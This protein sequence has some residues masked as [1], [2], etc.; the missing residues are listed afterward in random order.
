M[1][2][3]EI[4]ICMTGGQL[5]SPNLPPFFP[6]SLPSSFALCNHISQE[7]GPGGDLSHVPC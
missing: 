3:P 6:S 5:G 7:Q 4:W 2:A 1:C